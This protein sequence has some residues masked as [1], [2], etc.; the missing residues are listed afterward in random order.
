MPV[1]EN[2]YDVFA[3][4]ENY[5]KNIYFPKVSYTLKGYTPNA[6]LLL[7]ASGTTKLEQNSKGVIYIPNIS[8]KQYPKVLDISLDN[9]S[10]FYGDETEVQKYIKTG[11]WATRRLTGDTLQVAAKISNT[12]TKPLSNFDVYA[13][14]YDDTRT[15]YATGRTFVATLGGREE[16][17]VVFT[18][19]NIISPANADF[20]VVER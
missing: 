7:S 16:S 1:G 10:A 11:A 6:D 2:K 9:V 17:A 18:W 12:G 3:L 19:G 15:V 8:S 14:L 4:I 5:N 13:L 20:I